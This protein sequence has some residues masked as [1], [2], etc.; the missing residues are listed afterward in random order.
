M[1][2]RSA[3]YIMLNPRGKQTYVAKCEEIQFLMFS[4]RYL[5]LKTILFYNLAF[6]VNITGA[7]ATGKYYLAKT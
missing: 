2:R 6:Y 3:L 5:K 4:L 1:F 7:V